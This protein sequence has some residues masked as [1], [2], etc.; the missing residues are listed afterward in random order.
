[1]L[2]NANDLLAI[3]QYTLKNAAEIVPPFPYAEIDG[4]GNG[5]FL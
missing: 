2:A 3:L 1:M 5:N 4:N